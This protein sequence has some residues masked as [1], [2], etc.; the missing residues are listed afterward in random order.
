MDIVVTEFMDL[1]ALETLESDYTIHRD[2]SLWDKPD[3]LRALTADARALIVRNKTPVDAALL[4]ASPRLEVVGRL[5]VGLD[6][7]DLD[8]CREKNVTVCP[9]T[10][11]NADAVAEYA[12][13][14]AMVLLRGLIPA[15]QAIAQGVW[16]RTDHSAGRESAGRVFGLLG[17]GS[18]GHITGE[19]ARAMGF[20]V[21]AHDP[22]IADAAARE[23]PADVRIVSFETLLAQADVMS[24]HVPLTAETRG[25]LDKSALAAMKPGAIVINT[26]R[27]GIVDEAALA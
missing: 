3:A 16:S 11:A 24:I 2:E 7:I 22:A 26:A 19:R 6:N 12:V 1:A 25:L 4:E 17:Y 9:A 5:G 23:V 27:G 20:R 21:I 15:T 10:G 18:I 13:A 14:A 8:A